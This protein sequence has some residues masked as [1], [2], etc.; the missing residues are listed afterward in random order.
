LRGQLKMKIYA[1]TKDG[2][3]EVDVTV[4]KLK[5]MAKNGDIHAARALAKEAFK[6][7]TTAEEKLN[8]IIKYIS[9]DFTA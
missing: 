7:A 1:K 8:I 6:T 2:I 9:R 5:E 4:D 3:K